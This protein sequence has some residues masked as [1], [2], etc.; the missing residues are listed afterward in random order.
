M[1]GGGERQT[2]RAMGAFSGALLTKSLI[3]L[4]EYII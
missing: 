3:T 1:A 4:K 2:D